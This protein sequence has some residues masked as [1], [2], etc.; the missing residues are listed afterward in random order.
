MSQLR[1]SGG[2]GRHPGLKIPWGLARAGSI[3]ACGTIVNSL[4]IRMDIMQLKPTSLSW[5]VVYYDINANQIK[6]YNVL[7]YRAEEI[8]KLKKQCATKEEFSSR[9]RSI[10][11]H[12]Y[13]SKCEW[14]LIIEVDDNGRIWL[15]PWVGRRNSDDARV[16]V[17]DRE[18]FNWQQ[19]ADKHI[20]RQVYKNK[21]KIDAF[22]QVE[23]NWDEFVDYCWYTRLR[24]ERYNPKFHEQ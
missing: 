13:W 8:K 2:T 5:P 9:M 1:R 3:P 6:Q 20:S 16:D 14:E 22:D 10:M 7:Q 17:T 24:Y 11:M 15:M 12:D 18:D 23:W 19:F 21:A 4:S